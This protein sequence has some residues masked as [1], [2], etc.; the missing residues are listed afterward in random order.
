[1]TRLEL[2]QLPDPEAEQAI[3]EQM[4]AYDESERMSY[5]QIGLMALAVDR[6]GLWKFRQD[7]DD[8][9]PCRSFARWVRICC[10]Y[11]YSTVYAAKRDVEDISDVPAEDVAQIPQ[12]NFRTMKQLSTAV[13]RDPLVLAASKGRNEGLVA[14]VK[15]EWPEQ[16][17]EREGIFKVPLSETQMAEVEAAIAKALERGCASRS[18]ALWMI[19]VDFLAT[20]DSPLEGIEDRSWG[21]A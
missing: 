14:H 21:H 7:P 17:I 4:K 18:E 6:R 11:A 1:M 8:G 15:K 20:D 3:Y 12:S 10:P 9:L 5:A 16:H 13:R 2:D 19:A